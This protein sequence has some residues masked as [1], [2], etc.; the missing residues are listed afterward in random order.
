MAQRSQADRISSL[1]EE[2]AACADELLAVS[3]G[4]D[5]DVLPAYEGGDLR[6]AELQCRIQQERCSRL[7]ERLK[8]LEGALAQAAPG[9]GTGPR[10]TAEQARS[11]GLTRQL[12]QLNLRAAQQNEA[13]LNDLLARVRLSEETVQTA[14]ALR[15]TAELAALQ[16]ALKK[17]AGV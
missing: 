9:D 17:E 4:I 16:A 7:T 12:V 14:G 1:Q 13:F 6:I 10:I 15:S 8:A 2:A 5:T 11:I 3:R